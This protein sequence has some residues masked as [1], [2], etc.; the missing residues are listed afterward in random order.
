MRKL[1]YI[2]FAVMA[3]A[4]WFSSCNTNGCLENRNAL[5]YAGF[6]DSSTGSSITVDSVEIYGLGMSEDDPLSAAGERI[7]ALY[8]PMRS[9]QSTTGWV[10]SYKWAYLDSSIYNDTIVFDYTSTPRF[11]SEEC[12]VIYDYHI[13]QFSYTKHLIDSV[14]V[15]DSL[16]TNI[17]TERIHV[18]FRTASEDES[19]EENE[20]E[21]DEQE[22][23]SEEGGADE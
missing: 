13:T 10:F 16:I 11:A 19:D 23:E 20:D 4:V 8:L 5:P 21:P 22:D 7:S 12:G 2:L 1:L 15:S 14:V 18:Y 9:T 17:D 6:Y 3:S